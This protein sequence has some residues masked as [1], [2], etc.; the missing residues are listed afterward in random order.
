MA[1]KITRRAD[2]CLYETSRRKSSRIIWYVQQYL[3]P[4]ILLRR[5]RVRQFTRDGWICTL[6]RPCRTTTSV[7]NH[8]VI[9]NSTYILQ[10]CWEKRRWWWQNK[11]ATGGY[12]Y[13]KRPRHTTIAIVEW[14]CNV[15]QYLQSLMLLKSCEARRWW[16]KARVTERREYLSVSIRPCHTTVCELHYSSYRLQYCS[17]TCNTW[18]DRTTRWSSPSRIISCQHLLTGCHFG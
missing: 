16:S 9:C 3:H 15:Q 14:C 5:R 10:W 12:V 1:A 8:S 17:R 13:V 6:R 2:V 7:S 4:T 11:Q 18:E